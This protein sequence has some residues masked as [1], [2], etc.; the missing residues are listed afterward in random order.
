MASGGELVGAP[1]G[2]VARPRASTRGGWFH[3]E[4]VQGFLWVAPAFLYLAFFIAYPFFMSVYLSVSSAR[5]GSPDSHF[6][7][8]QNYTRLFADPTF[9]QT[10]RNSFVFTIGSE[11]IRLI[12]GLPLAFALNRSFKGKRIAQ[13][14]ILI[15]FVIPIALSSLAWKW[16]F[17][18]LYSVINWMLMRAHIIDYPWQWL[19][20]PGLGTSGGA[21]RS[22]RSSCS[23]D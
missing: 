22:R 13:G 8:L 10:V 7:G 16:M 18:S 11:L 3:R 9:W 20:E 12:I 1:A 6:V 15:P 14:I 4:S 17:D 19:G 2:S 21:S 5:V 23:P